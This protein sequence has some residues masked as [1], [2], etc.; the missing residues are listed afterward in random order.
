MKITYDVKT[1]F[2][3]IRFESGQCYIDDYTDGIDIAY[4]EV[5]DQIIGYD[6]HSACK[7]IVKFAEVTPAQKLGMLVKLYRK[8]LGMTQIDLNIACDI[9]LSTIKI[10][11]K[12]NKDT[13]I[14]NLSRLKRALPGID[15]NTISVSKIAS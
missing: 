14:E 6:L 13:S 11:E 12:G 2:M 5:D 1:D 8:R 4:S 9:S 15:L 3:S 7:S 10:I